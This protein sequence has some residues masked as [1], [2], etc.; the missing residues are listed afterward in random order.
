MRQKLLALIISFSFIYSA[1]SQVL[2]KYLNYVFPNDSLAG[3][4]QKE[5]DQKAL[6]GG[7]FGSE[8]KV[9]MYYMKR[10]YINKKY[11]Y[12]TNNA[13]PLKTPTP[14]VVAGPPCNNEDFEASTA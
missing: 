2:P 7:Y 9:I 11:G 14:P 5:A 8:Y 1:N 13:S 10:D 12:Y 6:Q 4:D 3:F